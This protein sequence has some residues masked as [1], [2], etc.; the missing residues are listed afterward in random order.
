M[1]RLLIT[2]ANGLVGDYLREAV[3][4]RGIVPLLWSGRAEVDLVDEAAVTRAFTAA[5]PEIVLHA[6]AL[7]RIDECQRLF[8]LAQRVN[9]EAPGHL[10]RLCRDAGAHIVYI[11]SDMVFSGDAAPYGTDGCVRPLS[12]YGVTKAE[13]ERRVLAH[14]GAVARLALLGGPSR[15]GR[16]SYFDSQVQALREGQPLHLFEDEWRTP[17]DLATAAE[18][19]VELA[20]ARADGI[21]HLGGPE[22]VSRVEMG[23]ILARVVGAD[24]KNILPTKR[25]PDRP[26]DVSLDS[27]RWR[28]AFPHV[29]WPTFAEGLAR[30]LAR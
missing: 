7:A 29:P 19:L 12:H 26:C 21:W 16:P 24:D 10:A 17:L 8:D 18:G 14:G 5:R 4:R 23:R 6:A 9:A 13:G 30:L 27:S 11:S 25:P 3:Q 2:G 1:P 20:L 15:V 28:E 22:R